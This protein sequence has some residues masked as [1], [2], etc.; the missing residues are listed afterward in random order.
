M[1]V[2]DGG[3]YRLVCASNPSGAVSYYDP[4]VGS[5]MLSWDYTNSSTQIWVVTKRDGGW[6]LWSAPL[7]GICYRVDSGRMT[8][9][10]PI[11]LDEY[12]G[13]DYASARWDI[14]DDGGTVTINGSTYPTCTIKSQNGASYMTAGGA[15]TQ[16]HIMSAQMD[17]ESGKQVAAQRFALVPAVRVA[18]S[19]LTTPSG[20]STTA[21]DYVGISTGTIT[22]SFAALPGEWHVQCRYR[23]RQRMATDHAGVMGTWGEWHELAT[24]STACHGWGDTPGAETVTCTNDGGRHVLSKGIAIDNGSTYDRTDVQIEVRQWVARWDAGKP[25][26]SSAG[27]ATIVTARPLVMD[28]VTIVRT[29]T[30][31]RYSGVIAGWSGLGTAR[32]TSSAIM[33]QDVE[34]TDGRWTAVVPM[35][36]HLAPPESARYVRVTATDGD[37]ITLDTT[38]PVGISSD[39]ESGASISLSSAWDGTI[40]TVKATT[41]VN[42]ATHAW[43]VLDEGHG[44][45]YVDLGDGPTWRLAPPIGREWRVMASVDAGARWAVKTYTM[46][47]VYEAIAAYHITSQDLAHDVAIAYAIKE[48]PKYTSSFARQHQTVDA[49]GR[50]RPASGYSQ[51]TKLDVSLS[52]SCEWDDRDDIDW[53]AHAS[54]VILRDPH[55]GWWQ[56]GVESVSIDGTHA[57]WLTYDVKLC[58]EVW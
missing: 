57:G 26:V 6:V 31:V 25:Y 54:H 49:G 21:G 19:G 12:G 1:P 50:I 47:A 11:V 29:P 42:G 2:T 24:G 35:E 39:S 53:L 36:M 30:G 5:T 8:D 10:T 16:G 44:T 17:A 27:T 7:V 43:I 18:M 38:S 37:G 9:G 51:E 45:S 48:R 28:K 40:A 56:C 58:G 23:I 3:V 22:P 20:I 33:P 52:G 46:A 41:S 32:V 14:T 15:G 13:A 4:Y 34:C 55:G